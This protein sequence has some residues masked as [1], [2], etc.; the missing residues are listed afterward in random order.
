MK[1][2]S[3]RLALVL[4]FWAAADAG[5]AQPVDGAVSA[6]FESDTASPASL[7]FAYLGLVAALGAVN[8]ILF[9]RNRDL[10]LPIFIFQS[11]VT[12]CLIDSQMGEPRPL[13]PLIFNVSLLILA[14]RFM[15]LRTKYPP[16]FWLA[17]LMIGLQSV[18]VISALV[19]QVLI[20]PGFVCFGL[21]GLYVLLLVT[22]VRFGRRADRAI[23]LCLFAL[24]PL[25]LTAFIHYLTLGLSGTGL[26]PVYLAI[27]AAI[28]MVLM[29]AALADRINQ[30][31]QQWKAEQTALLQAQGDALAAKVARQTA[32]FDQALNSLRETQG[33]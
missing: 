5:Q 4:C 11:L 6:I 9:L 24:S 26:A 20:P 15:P 21:A 3:I 22:A 31:R 19:G 16:A 12:A 13:I 8:L 10:T 14:N 27:G 33:Q 28:E 18:Q 23:L 1:S 29:S 25:L 17:W 30:R 7:Y 32:Q 2:L